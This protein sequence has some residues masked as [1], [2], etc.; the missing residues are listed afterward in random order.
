MSIVAVIGAGTM[1]TA[2]AA[3]LAGSQ[4]QVTLIDPIPEALARAK[5]R[6]PDTVNCQAVLTAAADAEVVIEAV[7]EQIGLK[8]RIFAELEKAVSTQCI[9]ATNTSGLSVNAIGEALSHPERLVGMHFFTPADIIPLVEVIRHRATTDSAV[10]KVLALLQ[11]LGKKPVVVQKDIPGFIGNRLQ[12]ALAREAM[13]LLEKGV[14]SSE[15]IDFVARWALGVRLVLTGPLE[16]RD[17]NGLD[18]HHAIAGYLYEDLE[19]TTSPLAILSDKV[20]R[21]ELGV[22]SGQGFYPWPEPQA[23]EASATRAKRLAALVQWLDDQGA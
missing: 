8:Q 13:S 23:S 4:H 21:G 22:K 1:G 16:Q 17:V 11:G 12:H 7:P 19:N 9:L 5:A 2:I 15:D 3:L 18:V 20:A 10:E 14:A 6:L